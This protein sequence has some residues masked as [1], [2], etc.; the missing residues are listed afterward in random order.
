MK[1]AFLWALAFACS[2][3]RALGEGEACLLATECAAGLVC[4]QCKPQEP[5]VCSRDVACVVGLFDASVPREASPT[6]AQDGDV[7][8]DAV[9]DVEDDALSEAAS[10]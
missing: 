10:D 7:A 6:D 5:R 4:V 1:Y 2:P 3:P 8:S 9:P